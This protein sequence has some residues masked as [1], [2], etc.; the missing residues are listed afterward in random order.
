MKVTNLRLDGLKL[1]TP[2]TFHDDRGFFKE[3]YHQP[4]YA[5]LGIST[6][7]VQDNH[8]F[9]QN[10]VIRGMHFQST[11]GQDKLVWVSQG[12]IFDVAVD[13]R[14]DS[15]TFGQ[16]E[17]VYLDE[18][19]HQQLFIPNGFAHGFCVV[20]VGGAHVHYKV[21]APYDGATEK[22]FRFDDPMIKIQW[23]SQTPI[24]STRDL[25]APSFSEAVK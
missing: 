17:G 21:S 24:I 9:S 13:L 1:I 25:E 20:S 2:R 5:D 12:K 6:N 7:F 16:W 8:S 23:P 19:S 18:E 10:N 22:T 3:T 11:P 14:K 15:P 4:R